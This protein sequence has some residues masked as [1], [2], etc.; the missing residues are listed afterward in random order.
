MV[1]SNVKANI[2][3]LDPGIPSKKSATQKINPIFVFMSE[4]TIIFTNRAWNN[5]STDNGGDVKNFYKGNKDFFLITLLTK[6]TPS[7][8]RCQLFTLL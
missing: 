4:G 6:A 8:T 7:N 2:C 3:I 1:D 5:F